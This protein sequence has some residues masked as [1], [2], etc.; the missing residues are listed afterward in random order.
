MCSRLK[1]PMVA[2]Y[3]KYEWRDEDNF[4][5]TKI[6]CEITLREY[7]YVKDRNQ[8][9]LEVL[10]VTQ[11]NKKYLKGYVSSENIGYEGEF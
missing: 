1:K 7:K 5:L 4:V 8:A 6:Y 10:V 2:N 3:C 11:A 9:L